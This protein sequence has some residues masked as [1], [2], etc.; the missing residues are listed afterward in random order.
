MLLK[1]ILY[2]LIA[3]TSVQAYALAPFSNTA[4]GVSHGQDGDDYYKY[5]FHELKPKKDG[6]GSNE[7]PYFR[8]V[9]MFKKH[10]E[11]TDE[12][13]HQHWK[14]VHADLTI[15]ANDV[16]IRI[17]RYVQVCCQLHSYLHPKNFTEAD[18]RTQF[19]QDSQAR[20]RIQPIVELG[21]GLVQVAPYDGLADLYAES[22]EK[23]V[24]FLTAVFADPSQVGDIP[25]FI[26]VSAGLT[27]MGGYDNLLFGEAISSSGGD[28]GILPTDK[29]LSYSR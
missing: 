8:F 6:K 25:N 17:T 29:R 16:G 10:P 23:V 5:T 15:R 13:F 27:V 24:E 11:V 3:L 7:Q 18:A 1:H 20:K 4:R 22:A 12:Y 26:D 9:T 21:Q 14:S 19:H 28:D 2:S